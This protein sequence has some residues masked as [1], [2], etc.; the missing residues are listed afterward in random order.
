MAGQALFFL[1][2]GD[3]MQQV[4]HQPKGAQPAADKAPQ[5]TAE[6][7]EEAKG[8]EGNLEAP[9]IQQ[10]LES[11]DGAGGDCP[12]TGVAVQA[13]DT[14]VFQPAPVNF[15]AEKAVQIPV[16][17]DGK[18]QLYRQ[19]KFLHPFTRSQCTPGRS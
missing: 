4:L 6:E 17:H 12:R 10:G 2:D 9:L 1:E 13:G 19:S 11:P 5:Q 16:G 18:Q 3:F 14:G 15:P 7:E 8:G